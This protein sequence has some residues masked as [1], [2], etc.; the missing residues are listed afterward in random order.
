MAVRLSGYARTLRADL[1]GPLGAIMMNLGP[2][3]SGAMH[4][5]VGTNDAAANSR[6]AASRLGALEDARRCEGQDAAGLV[7]GLPMRP[8]YS[9]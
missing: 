1:S 7:A 2:A 6:A 3:M 4:R 5:G 9:Q 8:C